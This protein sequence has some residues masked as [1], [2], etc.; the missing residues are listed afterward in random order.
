MGFRVLDLVQDFSVLRARVCWGG[1]GEKLSS[2]QKDVIG[3]HICIPG[4][5]ERERLCRSPGT[6]TQGTPSFC[7]DDLY[8]L[9]VLA[10]PSA[11]EYAYLG[12]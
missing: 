1:G 9:P 6:N 12:A 11:Y 4:Y 3:M 7:T 2:K 8:P 5:R 10:I